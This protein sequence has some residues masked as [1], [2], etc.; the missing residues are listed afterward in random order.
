M[1]DDEHDRTPGAVL[2][3]SMNDKGL[4]A[5]TLWH[6]V[7]SALGLF[8]HIRTGGVSGSKWIGIIFETIRNAGLGT[9]L[10]WIHW[11]VR[12]GGDFR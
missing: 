2:R 9:G 8:V 12:D 5:R 6:L 4:T 1:T 11:L 7:H 3:S 10:R